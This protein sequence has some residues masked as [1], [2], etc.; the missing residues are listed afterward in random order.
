MR[1]VVGCIICRVKGGVGRWAGVGCCCGVIVGFDGE[2]LRRERGMG[3]LGQG[4]EVGVS[5]LV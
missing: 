2:R 5:G 1:R 3:L 4:G